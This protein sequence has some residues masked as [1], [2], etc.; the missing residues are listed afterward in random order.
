M[1]LNGTIRG[2]ALC[3]DNKKGETELN[4]IRVTEKKKMLFFFLS[5]GQGVI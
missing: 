5:K 4:A 3:V 1:P 2:T